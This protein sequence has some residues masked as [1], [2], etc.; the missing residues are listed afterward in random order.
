MLEYL[1]YKKFKKYKTEKEA[2]E[3]AAAEGEVQ[4]N[5]SSPA[6]L[7]SPGKLHPDSRPSATRRQTSSQSVSTTASAAT[8]GG[9]PAPLLNRK[10][11]AFFR[12]ILADANDVDSDDESVRPALPPRSKTPEYIWEDSDGS[13]RT[14]AATEKQTPKKAATVAVDPKDANA[15]G[16]SSKI[17]SKIAFLFNKAKGTLD[18]KDKQLAPTKANVPPK[19][20]AREEDDLS[21]VLDDLNLSARNNK[22]VPLS[23]ES[24]ELVSKFT[25]VLKDLVNGV[26]TAADDL[27]AL[28]EDRD[29]TLAKTFDKLPNSMKKLVTQLPDKF[30]ASLGP[31]VLAAAAKAQ[32]VN[33]AEFAAEEGIKGAAKKM[34]TPTSLADLVTKPGA[35]VGMLKAIVNALKLRW[36]AFI[37]ANVIWSVSIFL[38]LFVLWY[39]HKRGREERIKRENAPEIIDGSGRIEE[40]PDDPALMAG[41]SR[42]RTEPVVRSSDR[43]RS[44]RSERSRR[45]GRHSSG[46]TTPQRRASPGPDSP[47]RRSTRK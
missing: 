35:V 29:G 11:E 39:C 5:N 13:R 7:P 24:S 21:R 23:A 3:A 38:L 33:H 47:R 6:P 15:P 14:A 10:D 30:T 27:K 8:G 26:P 2:K 28:V 4:H 37:G 40:L 32:G 22:A 18:D 45:S 16:S 25:L 42:S 36:P 41:P 46:R 1:S 9:G 31:E 19:E 43:P 20:A 34:F 44:Q 17:P 12:R